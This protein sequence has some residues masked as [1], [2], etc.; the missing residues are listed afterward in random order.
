M[1]KKYPQT[2]EAKESFTSPLLVYIQSRTE[3]NPNYIF[4]KEELIESLQSE[5]REVR[6]EM[7]KVAN[8]YPIISLSKRKGYR[9]GSFS[10][11]TTTAELAEL[12]EDT[13]HAIRELESRVQCLQARMK[14]LI[15]LKVKLEE[16]FSQ[17]RLQGIEI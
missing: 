16:E 14:P 9:L 2:N 8:F 11:K 6:R 5:D 12:Y 15:A 3:E 10:E 17:T 4:T 7:E 13:T 1:G